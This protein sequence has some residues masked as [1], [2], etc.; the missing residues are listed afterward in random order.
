MHGLLA[1]ELRPFFVRLTVRHES[2]TVGQEGEE[3]A[4]G[5]EKELLAF[6]GAD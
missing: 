2:E 6:A 4:V 3:S 1:D 5:E